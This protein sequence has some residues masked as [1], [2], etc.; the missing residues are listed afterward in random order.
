M[1]VR[2]PP[3]PAAPCPRTRAQ[4]G[5]GC[6]SLNWENFWSTDSAVMLVRASIKPI[7][8]QN[9]AACEASA[10]QADRSTRQAPRFRVRA[11]AFSNRAKYVEMCKSCDCSVTWPGCCHKR[12]PSPAPNPHHHRG[13]PRAP[14]PPLRG[15]YA[16]G[17]LA[18]LV[19]SS[20][21]FDGEWPS[22]QAVSRNKMT[23]KPGSNAHLHGR[24]QDNT[25]PV[26]ADTPTC[27]HSMTGQVN[28]TTCKGWMG[29]ARRLAR[30]MGGVIA[31]HA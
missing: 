22:N 29:G 13:S 31:R 28:A 12:L 19:H 9:T 23:V 20:F 30:L 24:R 8:W 2:A 6:P 1:W 15:K 27:C 25:V 18:T 3:P 7:R 4:P 14:M 17:A 11:A 21:N 26:H 16:A 5:Q 10:R